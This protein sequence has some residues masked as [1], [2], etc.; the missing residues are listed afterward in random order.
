MV[1][2]F[3]IQVQFLAK[4]VMVHNTMVSIIEWLSV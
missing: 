1:T 4:A 2:H 3:I